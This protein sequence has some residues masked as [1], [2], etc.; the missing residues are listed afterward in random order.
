MHG[1]RP[2]GVT[3][4]PKLLIT[5]FVHRN[6]DYLGRCLDWAA[7]P[8]PE[9]HQKQFEAIAPGREPNCEMREARE[10]A[11]RYDGKRFL[12]KYRFI[13]LRRV[14]PVSTYESTASGRYSYFDED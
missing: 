1:A 4:D 9:I 5:G 7:R 12:H 11:E 13:C 14:G 6:V 8:V 3:R 2:S 10:N